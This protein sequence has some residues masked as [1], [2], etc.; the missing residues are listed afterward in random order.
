MATSL[1]KVKLLASDP[2][3]ANDTTMPVYGK[4][5]IPMPILKFL[6]PNLGTNHSEVL[7]FCNISK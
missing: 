6:G 1:S 7:S 4:K 5:S 3:A 2:H